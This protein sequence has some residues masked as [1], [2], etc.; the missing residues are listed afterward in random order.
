MAD[1]VNC[2]L[3]HAK[4]HCDSS[5][6]KCVIEIQHIVGEDQFDRCFPGGAERWWDVDRWAFVDI[7]HDDGENPVCESACLVGG[8][9]AN[10]E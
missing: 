8:P 3:G 4:H 1:G 10:L 6:W 5:G 9:Y 2:A 7:T